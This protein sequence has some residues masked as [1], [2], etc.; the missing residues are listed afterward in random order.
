MACILGLKKE[1]QQS[2]MWS[3]GCSFAEMYSKEPSWKNTDS[4]NDS[5]VVGEIEH[6]K[7]CLQ[8]Q[9]MPYCAAS[10]RQERFLSVIN[11]CLQY[12]SKKRLAAKELFRVLD[13]LSLA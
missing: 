3:L 9:M 1:T 10:I 13:K 8:K 6:I 12:D 7:P 5:G 11:K 4:D 2:D